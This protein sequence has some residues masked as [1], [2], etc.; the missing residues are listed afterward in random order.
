M[1][2]FGT[3]V[4]H[5]LLQRGQELEAALE[6]HAIRHLVGADAAD[7]LDRLGAGGGVDR[8]TPAAGYS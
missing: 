8:R 1:Q 4:A 2:V 7:L 3:D 5:V 6:Q